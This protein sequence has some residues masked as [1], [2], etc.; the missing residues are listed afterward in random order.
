MWF[1]K[2]CTFVFYLV[3]LVLVLWVNIPQGLADLLI[4]L[5]TAMMLFT[6]VMYARVYLRMGRE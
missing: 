2:V 4:L 1:G 3:V 5:C 6:F